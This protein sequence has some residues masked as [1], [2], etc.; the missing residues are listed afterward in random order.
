VPDADI[1]AVL[2]LVQRFDP[3]G[4]AART[5]SECLCVQLGLLSPDTPALDLARGVALAHLAAL[6]RHGAGKRAAALGVSPEAMD[7]AVA[8]LRSLDPRPG[9]QVGGGDPEY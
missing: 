6:A 4:V 5:L 8:L 3:V 2:H 1:E 9:A 7:A